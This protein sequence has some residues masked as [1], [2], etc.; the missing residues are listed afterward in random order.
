[1]KRG[2]PATQ[3][4]DSDDDGD[5]AA[6]PRQPQPH[7]GQADMSPAIASSATAPADEPAA[8]AAEKPDAG[9]ATANLPSSS[10]AKKLRPHPALDDSDDEDDTGLA[11][12]LTCSIC[13]GLLHTATSVIPC[14]HSF[15]AGCVSVWMDKQHTCP[16]CR[17]PVTHLTRNHQLQTLA[18]A[19]AAKLNPKLLR[20]AEDL[21]DLDSKS[22]VPAGAMVDVKKVFT[23]AA[24]GVDIF[25]EDN[26]DAEDEEA[27]EGD[28][29]DEDDGKCPH[30]PPNA[31]PDGFSCDENNPQHQHCS[32]CYRHMPMRFLE[33][34][35]CKF[36]RL[37]FCDAYFAPAGATSGG[38]AANYG[39]FQKL[40]GAFGGKCFTFTGIPDL[41]FN[42]NAYERRVLT[43][44]FNTNGIPINSIF[45]TI[46]E[47]I[48][49]GNEQMST[50]TSF[51][52]TSE[53]DVEIRGEDYSCF[54]CAQKIFGEFCFLYRSKYLDAGLLPE[55]V[56]KRQDC[57]PG[58][59]FSYPVDESSSPELPQDFVF[60]PS[61]FFSP[62]PG[63]LNFISTSSADDALFKSI[64]NTHGT[65]YG[66]DHCY[67]HLFLEDQ[68]QPQQ[69]IYRHDLKLQGLESNLD[70]PVVA[71]QQS[72]EDM[73]G[74]LDCSLF[75]FDEF[76]GAIM[77]MT[78]CNDDPDST[79]AA[80]ATVSSAA[81][82]S[83]SPS[84]TE[85]TVARRMSLPVSVPYPALN[86]TFDA[87]ETTEAT[88]PASA[89][90]VCAL[91]ATAVRHQ[92]N[93]PKGSR[94]RCYS[95]NAST[96]AKAPA[97]EA[98][99][100]PSASPTLTTAPATPTPPAAV[101]DSR[102]RA[103]ECATC[104]NRF[105][106][107]Q[108]LFRHEA[109]HSRSRIYVCPRKCGSSFARSDALT[110]HV[111]GSKTCTD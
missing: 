53:S 19:Y 12:N 102:V 37:Q 48:E 92:R 40:K 73:A 6:P 51:M 90:D 34:Q 105:L 18:D 72:F 31:A 67:D 99:G 75:G 110:R 9:S 57:W 17:T 106:R 7:S 71:L 93:K 54:T 108:D 89:E 15:C 11:E 111:R 88:A 1:M 26:E 16:Q 2:P 56:K 27:E 63:D 60:C 77:Q 52:P 45:T 78:T 100:R 74:L 95:A 22:K 24:A 42:N 39:H 76:D 91:A 61:M 86:G 80:T 44:I 55:A 38:C 10:P 87:T 97:R 28:D 23:G 94:R 47:N 41:A 36:C 21:A 64:D 8:E 103:Y 43:E 101:A 20:S 35:Q 70:A 96:P 65:D 3:F 29:D 83:S 107:R 69:Q 62:I 14:L 25:D 59:I 85:V 66:H 33:N 68:L 5:D 49:S 32:R 82:R 46:L 104:L 30:C 79:A 58:F 13:R 4:V 84:S 81:S 98:V 50:K 109:T